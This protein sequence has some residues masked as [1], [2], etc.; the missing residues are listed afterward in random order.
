MP[1]KYSQLNDMAWLYQKYV[2]E[3]MSTYEIAKVIHCYQSTVV[4]ALRRGGIHMRSLSKPWSGSPNHNYGKQFSSEV[5]ARMSDAHKGLCVGEKHPLF[6][7][8]HIE[9]TKGKIRNARRLQRLPS[10]H[11]KPEPQF[12][13]ICTKSGLPFEYTG[14][15]TLWIGSEDTTKLNPD[16]CSTNDSKV[17]VEVF[18]DYWHDPA[19]NPNVAETATYEY[20]NERFKENGY[21]MI[22]FW[23][24]D[25]K[26]SDAEAFVLATLERAGFLVPR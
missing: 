7:M 25:L 6:G 16:F 15:S 8:K 21:H 20:R 19:P 3:R 10:H 1:S 22:V 18:G 11:T 24:T 5:R 4:A 9:G 12:E 2:T 23:E 14:N 17:V 13:E 26:R